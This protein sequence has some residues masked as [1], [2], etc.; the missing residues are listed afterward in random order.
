[1]VDDGL[2]ARLRFRPRPATTS[3]RGFDGGRD[4]PLGLGGRRDGLLYVPDTAEPG[5]AVLVFL[6]GANGSGRDHLRAVLA[7]ADRY[8]VVLVAPDSR[9]PMT[10]D[11]IAEGRIGPDPEF[12]DRVLDSVVDRLAPDIDTARLAIGGVSDGASYAL[13]LGLSNGDIFSTVLAFS[14]GFLAVPEPAG[15]PRVFVSHGTADPI[16]PIDACSRSF[17]PALRRAGYEVRFHEFDGGHTV[18]P[19]ISDEALRWWLQGSAEPPRA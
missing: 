8:G 4:E 18:P 6:H 14:P 5:A 19:P 10:W 16:L 17:V 2:G 1:M 11:L 3:N 12:L 7:A 15:R 9:D 13:T